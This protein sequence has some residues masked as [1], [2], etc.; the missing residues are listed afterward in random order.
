LRWRTAIAQRSI[1]CRSGVVN[2]EQG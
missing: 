2:L 1:Q